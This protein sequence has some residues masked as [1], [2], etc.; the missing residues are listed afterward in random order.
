MSEP[1]SSLGKRP[2]LYQFKVK[3]VGYTFAPD[4][5]TAKK[6]VAA[7]KTLQYGSQGKKVRVYIDDYSP[8]KVTKKR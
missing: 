5:K 3:A 7:P 8:K 2:Q 6:Q 1:G 4:Q